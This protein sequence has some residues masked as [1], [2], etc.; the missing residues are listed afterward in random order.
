[1]FFT[2]GGMVVWEGDTLQYKVGHYFHLGLPTD[3]YIK[4]SDR[5]GDKDSTTMYGYRW[6]QN[7]LAF[8]RMTESE[9]NWIWDSRPAHVLVRQ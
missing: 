2:K 7:K 5:G 4:L 3:D 9:E 6:E 1:M 8:Y